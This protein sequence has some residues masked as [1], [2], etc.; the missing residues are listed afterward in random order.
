MSDLYIVKTGLTGLTSTTLVEK[1][2][3]HIL[4]CTANPNVTLP[5]PFMADFTAAV[6]ALEAANIAVFENGG[7]KDTLL[8]TAARRTLEEFIRALAGYVQAQC[9]DDPV[10][11]ASTGFETR[12]MP[13]PVGVVDAAK[14][15]RAARGKLLGDIDVRW[16]SVSGRIMYALYICAGDPK[17]E[18]DWSLLLQTS[19]NF[20]TA[21]NLISDKPY[22][23]RV[24][25]IGTAGPGPVS[26]SAWSK[27]A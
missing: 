15:L 21:I 1:G 6:D 12:R 23:F 5:V 27:A 2:R 4:D 20:H 13:S 10:K 18:A 19:K 16:D 22:Y 14:N 11:I 9:S 7:R 26:D 17:V 25:A 3:T 24:V 8:R